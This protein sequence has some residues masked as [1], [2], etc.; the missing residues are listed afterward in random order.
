MAD[1]H[2]TTPVKVNTETL[3]ILMARTITNHSQLQRG[4]T[5]NKKLDH[6]MVTLIWFYLPWLD[7]HSVIQAN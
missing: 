6:C 3:K 2:H 7:G 1:L 4:G 5:D